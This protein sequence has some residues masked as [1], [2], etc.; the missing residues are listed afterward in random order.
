[1]AED[2]IPKGQLFTHVYLDRSELMRDSQQFRKRIGFFCQK[3]FLDFSYA[4][5]NFLIL[6]MGVDITRRGSGYHYEG[7]FERIEAKYMFN[8]ITLIWRF[9]I[10]E[11]GRTPT[12]KYWR[13]FVQRAMKEENLGYYLDEECGVHYFVDKEFESNRVSTLRC[14]EE[15]RYSGTRQAF[16]HAF[17]ELDATPPHTKDAIRS[18]FE[19][20]EILVKQMVETQR[21]NKNVVQNSLKKIALEAYKDDQIA[22]NSVGKV[23]MGFGEWVDAIH[24]YRHGQVVPEP[25]DPPIE[26]AIYILSSGASFLRWLVEI[27]KTRS[28]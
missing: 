22:Q 21:L 15:S 3:E 13:A 20:L 28:K 17:E 16:E 2:Q 7:F 6:E 10:N 26:F 1:M 24:N 23:F 9:L 5:G 27:D 4:L 11:G 18:I 25:K 8:A 19:S 12:G 14:L